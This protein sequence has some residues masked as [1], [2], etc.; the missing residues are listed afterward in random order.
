M[1][2]AFFTLGIGV[3]AVVILG[4]FYGIHSVKP[5]P[6]DGRNPTN[7][8]KAHRLTVDTVKGPGWSH[9]MIVKD[10]V[11]DG[12]I[13]FKVIGHT[14]LE[15]GGAGAKEW[16]ANLHS[17]QLPFGYFCDDGPDSLII[18]NLPIAARNYAVT[19]VS[20]RN[21]ALRSQKK[22]EPDSFYARTT[23]SLPPCLKKKLSRKQADSANW[24]QFFH[25]SG[26]SIVGVG[27]PGNGQPKGF[28][29]LTLQQGPPNMGAD[30]PLTDTTHID[31]REIK[32][33]LEAVES[34]IF[35]RYLFSPHDRYKDGYILYDIDDMKKKFADLDFTV[36]GEKGIGFALIDQNWR[37]YIDGERKDSVIRDLRKDVD[38]LHDV[39]YGNFDKAGKHPLTS[40]LVKTMV[41]GDTLNITY[42]EYNGFYSPPQGWHIG[43]DIVTFIHPDGTTWL[44]RGKDTVQ[45]SWRLNTDTG[46]MSFPYKK[47][48]VTTKKR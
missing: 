28:I 39:I 43:E 37:N 1:K 38:H 3:V 44:A 4:E 32:M 33:R 19:V 26:E 41:I 30:L 21:T 42:R 13:L 5:D 7:Y 47:K 9:G 11:I 10:T 25:G 48:K 18:N 36:N 14:G 12:M 20:S 2:K 6:L 29:P 15:A 31:I 8:L 24:G 40:D 46:T 35:G 45:V 22:D 27:T 17:R 34:T 23:I 16:P